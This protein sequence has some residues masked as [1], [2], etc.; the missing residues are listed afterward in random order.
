MRLRECRKSRHTAVGGSNVGYG[1]CA[2]GLEPSTVALKERDEVLVG[3]LTAR[4]GRSLDT[5]RSLSL[6]GLL[7]DV[8]RR[9]TVLVSKRATTVPGNVSLCSGAGTADE[10]LQATSRS[11]LGVAHPLPPCHRPAHA[12]PSRSYSPTWSGPRRSANASTPSACRAS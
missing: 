9:A 6:S 10:T 11:A 1:V 3:V 2:K 5:A 4:V 7:R 8:L 12:E